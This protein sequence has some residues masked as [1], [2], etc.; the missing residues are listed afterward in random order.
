MHAAMSANDVP[1]CLRLLRE[2]ADLKAEGE[3]KNVCLISACKMRSEDVAA[4]ILDIST[5][6]INA[7]NTFGT[8]SLMWASIRGHVNIVARL[9][10]AGVN[11]DAKQNGGG[12][13]ALWHAL[14][15][16]REDVALQLISAGADVNN[17]ENGKSCLSIA[18]GMPA[19]K[20]ALKAAGAR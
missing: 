8:T 17:G 11:L 19:V 9:I 10:R 6:D 15:N 1:L 4:A 13:P 5:E 16:K 18:N 14:E 2:G 12:G 7:A 20:E 3:D